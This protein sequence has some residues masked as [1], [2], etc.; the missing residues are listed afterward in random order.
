MFIWITVEKGLIS[1]NISCNKLLITQTKLS[2]E[3]LRTDLRN[4]CVRKY[5]R[6]RNEGNV[7]EYEKIYL[8]TVKKEKS[9]LYVKRQQL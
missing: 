5:L 9:K 6:L 7:G 3:K 8:V 4:S 2:C 1:Y